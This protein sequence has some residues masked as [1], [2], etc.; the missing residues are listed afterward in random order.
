M[1]CQARLRHV[2]PATRRSQDATQRMDFAARRCSAHTS[3]GLLHHCATHRGDSAGCK[4][5]AV[6]TQHVES[7][8]AGTVEHT[9]GLKGQYHYEASSAGGLQRRLASQ[10]AGMRAVIAVCSGSAACTCTLRQQLWDAPSAAAGR[11]PWHALA[12]QPDASRGSLRPSVESVSSG[13]LGPVHGSFRRNE[14]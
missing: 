4:P 11:P 10:A 13:G 6:G 3:Q 5:A 2:A 8:R 9:G 14:E 12:Q 1:W 7:A